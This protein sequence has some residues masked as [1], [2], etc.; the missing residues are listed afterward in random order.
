MIKRVVAIAAAFGIALGLALAPGS[1][2]HASNA[3]LKVGGVLRNTTGQWVVYQDGTHQAQNLAGVTQDTA[4]IRVTF[5]VVGSKVLAV[6]CTADETLASWGIQVGCSVTPTYADIYFYRLV[7][8]AWTRQNP[9]TLKSQWG[10]VW[11]YGE[12]WA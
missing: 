6:T 9:A 10:N 12:L 8:G 1:A 3:T 11:V 7:N 5:G 4:K 2:S